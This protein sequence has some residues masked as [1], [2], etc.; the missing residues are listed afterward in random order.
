ERSRPVSSLTRQTIPPTEKR[1]MPG[2]MPLSVHSFAKPFGN[3]RKTL[4]DCAHPVPRQAK[5]VY[6]DS[7]MSE[8]SQPLG[9]IIHTYQRYDPKNFPSPTQPPPDMLSGAFDHLLAYGSLH[10]LSDEELARAVRIDPSQIAG[11]G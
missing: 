9:G 10:E 1:D 4:A 11:L 7:A 5:I 8:H 3:A 2:W 6:N